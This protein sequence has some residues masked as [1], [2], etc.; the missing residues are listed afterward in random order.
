M[1][2]I[3][4]THKGRRISLSKNLKARPTTDF[5]KENIFNVLSNYIDIED[6][7]VLDLFSGT[8][9]ISYE[10]ASRE[11]K[12][13]ISVEKNFTHHKQIISNI[14]ELGFSSI[15]AIKGDCFR[16]VEKC[17]KKFDIIFADPPYDL[18][19]LEILPNM[20]IEKELINKDGLLIFEHSRDFDF[21][22]L[23]GFQE[24]RTYGS[25]NFSIFQF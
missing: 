24:V 17:K 11:A 14:K 1:R 20:I 21:S 23:K 7:T 6:K 10:F 25:V 2:I 9:G 13:I 3:S 8:G 4:G 12:D 18:P 5:A 19:K 15:L 16:Y 22:E